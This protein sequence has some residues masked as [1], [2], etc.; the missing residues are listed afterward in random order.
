LTTF[1]LHAY[2]WKI[3]F[4]THMLYIFKR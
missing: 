1:A 3:Q 4:A 2:M